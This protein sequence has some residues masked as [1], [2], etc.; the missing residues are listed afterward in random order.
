MKAVVKTRHA[1]GLEF[2]KTPDPVIGQR[3]VLIKVNIASICGTDVHIYDW[4]RWA[5]QRLSPPRIL[6][7]EFVGTVAAV[8]EEVTLVKVGDCVSAESHLTC[9]HCYQCNNGY[10]EVCRNFKLLGVDHDGTFA[11]FFVLPEHV[12][13]K[14]SSN[15]PH[16]WAT[17]QEPFGNAVDTVLVEDVA[18]KTVLILGAGPIGLFAAGIAKA[19]G[20]SLVIVSD[21]NNYRLAISKKWGRMLPSIPER[22]TLSGLLWRLQKYGGG[23]RSGVFWQ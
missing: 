12:L 11:E 17:I 6:G 18:A 22:R 10:S 13:W 2:V 15:I 21:P 3:E 19:C 16:E 14:N 7:H 20:A 9:G 23:R 1:K 5:Q 4:T 8:G